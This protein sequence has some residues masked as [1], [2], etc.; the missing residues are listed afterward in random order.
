MAWDNLS[1]RRITNK[2]LQCRDC[3]YR[4]EDTEICLN[5]SQ[6]KAY[7]SKP[8]GVLLNEEDCQMYQ[9]EVQ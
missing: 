5:T 2:D 4:M 7:G 9:K 1:A 3:V 8:V 6:C